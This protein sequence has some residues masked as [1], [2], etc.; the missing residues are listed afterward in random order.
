MA[1][2]DLSRYM[3]I[4]LQNYHLSKRFCSSFNVGAR[5]FSHGDGGR[6]RFPPLKKKRHT[7]FCPVSRG[8]VHT[9]LGLAI[10]PF[11]TLANCS[12]D[13]STDCRSNVCIPVSH[14]KLQ[15]INNTIGVIMICE[16]GMGLKGR[17]T[18]NGL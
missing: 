4:H 6:K 12:T 5:S 7:M 9:S 15:A 8:G 10:F 2:H 3:V 13:C 17:F 11:V 14:T 16:L 1:E 18:Q